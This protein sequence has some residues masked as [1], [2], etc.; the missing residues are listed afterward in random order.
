MTS[1][2]TYKTV[3]QSYLVLFFI[4]LSYY[5]WEISVA[6]QIYEV[7]YRYMTNSRKAKYILL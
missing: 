7:P 3:S 1:F 6:S 2:L 5:S 4:M